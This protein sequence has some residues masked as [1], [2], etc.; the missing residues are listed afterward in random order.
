ML[1]G[2]AG[3]VKPPKATPGEDPMLRL[4]PLV[5][6]LAL[7]AGPA[8]AG[9]CGGFFC[10]FAPMNQV[11]ERI[12]FVDRGDSV[13]THVQIAYNGT[14]QDFA[15]ILPVPSRPD[16]AVSHNELFRQLQFATQPTFLLEWDEGDSDCGPFFP[17]FVRTLEDAAAESGGVTVV[18]EE[19]V[20]PYEAVVLAA[21][22]PGAVLDWLL[23]NGYQLTG[24]GPTLLRPYIDAGMHFLALRL[25]P[26]RELGDLQPIAMTYA[27]ERP[28]IPIMLT[29]VATEP[30]LGVT[31]WVLGQAR[32]VPVNFRHVQI[33]EALIDW[34][35]GG[36]NYDDVVTAAVDEAEGGLAFVTDYAGPAA[37]MEE[38]LYTEGRWDLDRLRAVEHPGRLVDELLRQGFPRDAQMQALFRRHIPLPP[39]VLTEGALRVVFRGNVEAYDRAVAD[40]TLRAVVERAFYNDIDAFE[41]W[42][43]ELVFDAG[44]FVDDLEAAVVAPLRGAQALF[45]E[46]PVLTRLYT[47]LSAEEMHLDPIF[48]VNPDL[49]EVSNLRTAAARWECEGDPDSVRFEELTLVVTLKDGREVRSNPFDGF[50]PRPFDAPAAAVIEQLHTTGAPVPI[51]RLTAVS[52]SESALPGA[53]VLDEV[54]PNPFNAAV[55]VPYR[56]PGDAVDR[57]VVLRVHNLLGQPVRTLVDAVRPPG[58]HTARWDGRGEDGRPVASGVYVVRLETPLHSLARKVLYLR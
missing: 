13:T 47:T 38:R 45:G 58:R 23:S 25:A 11:S 1:A 35:N 53:F 15:W 55:V 49:P 50:V 32:A 16:L 8:P 41:E 44:A 14:A 43:G 17:P 37:L 46:F 29:A 27:A 40:G 34:F 39:A 20:G 5:P 48:D 19:R 10:S 51:R 57:R 18:S 22:D 9:A 52:E 33:N 42:T 31:A 24:L 12:L 6:L 21:D 56:V 26:D 4:L 30:D 2:G 7:L 54:Y 36:I 28:M 3:A